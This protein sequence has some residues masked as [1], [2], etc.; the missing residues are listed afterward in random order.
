MPRTPDRAPGPA[1]EEDSI[2]FDDRGSHPPDV[3]SVY[4]IGNSLYAKDGTGSFDLRSA[5]GGISEGQHE[6]LDTLVHEVAEDS[7]LEVVRSGTKISSI[8]YWTDSGKT[9]KIREVLITRTTGKVS[10]I[11]RKHYDGTG[12]IITGQTLTGTVT[13]SNSKIANVSWVQS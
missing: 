8:V 13:R 3:G 5:G 11:V 2:L 1:R 9:V 6:D 7:Y 4:R 12:A 10:Q